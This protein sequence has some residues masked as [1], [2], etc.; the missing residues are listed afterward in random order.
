MM[1]QLQPSAFA[2]LNDLI[3]EVDSIMTVH[4]EPTLPHIVT[5]K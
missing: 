1:S 4:L 2:V 3:V 5:S